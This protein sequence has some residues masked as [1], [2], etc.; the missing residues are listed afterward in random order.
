MN[1]KIVVKQASMQGLR[2]SLNATVTGMQGALDSME[3]ELRNAL[4]NEWEG[5]AQEAFAAAK[6]KWTEVFNSMHKALSD[7]GQLVQD[8][9]DGYNDADK[10]AQAYFEI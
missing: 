5:H 8:A 4:A 1:D 9:N 3:S 7:H 6:V 2:D 10:K